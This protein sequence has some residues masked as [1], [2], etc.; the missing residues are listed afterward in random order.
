[1]VMIRANGGSRF[2]PATRTETSCMHFR[3]S[4]CQQ[5][6]YNRKEV[7]E[8]FH[9]PIVAAYALGAMLFYLSGR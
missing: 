8:A 4:I 2:A 9:M 3:A 6:C 1:M 7:E 5:L